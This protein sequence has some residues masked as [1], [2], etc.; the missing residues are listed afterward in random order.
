MMIDPLPAIQ[1]MDPGRGSTHPSGPAGD[2]GLGRTRVAEGDFGG[3]EDAAFRAAC[4]LISR[5]AAT[6]LPLLIL[7]ETGT[8]KE[9]CARAA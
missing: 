8:G 7:G 5:V 4:S 2:P 1:P 3:G 9:R 6:E